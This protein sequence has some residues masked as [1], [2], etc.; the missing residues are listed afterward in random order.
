[1]S[2]ARAR[3]AQRE[4]KIMNNHRIAALLK[5]PACG[6]QCGC[7]SDDCTIG[8]AVVRA[9]TTD[10]AAIGLR[11]A[12]AI[13]E[14]LAADDAHASVILLGIETAIEEQKK[15]AE[16][17]RKREEEA[18]LE[19]KAQR[20]E[21]ALIARRQREVDRLCLPFAITVNYSGIRLHM[22][23]ASTKAKNDTH[24]RE[25]SNRLFEIISMNFS[26]DDAWDNYM[27]LE[28]DIKDDEFAKHFEPLRN[29]DADL[30]KLCLRPAP[31]TRKE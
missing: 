8:H 25:E 2:T 13:D 15:R 1:M 7:V 30:V 19:A 16:H 22:S 5:L 24:I 27:H 4:K 10:N 31:S 29:L 17:K 6:R 3:T 11:K 9:C 20:I 12:K 23:D 28:G 14:I 18:I 26:I 21:D